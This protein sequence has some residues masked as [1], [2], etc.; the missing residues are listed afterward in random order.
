MRLVTFIL[1]IL[2]FASCHCNQTKESRKSTNQLQVIV[3]EKS[4][5]ELGGQKQY[6]EITS[7]SNKNPVL[8]FLHGGPGWPQTPQ[9]RYFNS[10]LTKTFTLVAWDQSGCGKS[11]LNDSV[12]K[13]LSLNQIINDAHEL[14]Q[15]LKQKFHQ[16]KIYLAGYSWGSIV[17]MHLAEK[18]PED[19]LIYVGISQVINMKKGI[20]ISREWIAQKAKEKSD[21]E[22]L[23]ILSR[24]NTSD[25]TLCNSDLECFIL[26]YGLLNKYNGAIYDPNSEKDEE[27][28]MKAYKD[29]ENYDWNKGF[30]FSAQHLEKDMF[31]TDLTYIK[32][33]QLPVIFFQGRHDWNVPSVLVEEFEKNLIA[34]KKSIVWFEKSGHGLLIEEASNFN[35][36]MISELTQ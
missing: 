36:L 20:I 8:L 31:S 4:F 1:C 10:D 18:Y 2:F 21:S 17:G 23:K 9:L 14:T 33:L 13:N 28:S 3:A 34:P 12:P 5:I 6:V 32:R 27:K 15:I 35:K 25:K 29:Y 30:Q 22:T 16:S 19:Y 24:L 26:Q 11:Y 7:E